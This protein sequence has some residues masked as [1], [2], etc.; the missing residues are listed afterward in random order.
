MLYLENF[1]PYLTDTEQIATIRKK[2]AATDKMVKGWFRKGLHVAS[3]S[4][5]IGSLYNN[6]SLSSECSVYHCQSFSVHVVDGGG[7][8]LR[9]RLTPIS[10]QRMV[11]IR[12]YEG[13]F[14]TLQEIREEV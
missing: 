4:A 7:A 12:E 6:I 8:Y 3:V 11:P 1:L 2:N 5:G 13:L 9:S 10:C 14:S